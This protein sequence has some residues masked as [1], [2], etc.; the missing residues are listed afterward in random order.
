MVLPKCRHCHRL[1]LKQFGH[2]KK[3]RDF[4]G[5]RFRRVRP[6]YGV[7]LDILREFLANGTFGRVCRIGGAHYIAPMLDGV[8]AL[9]HQDDHRAFRHKSDQ[10]G[11]E[12][13]FSMDLVKSLGL[14]LGKPDHF[15]TADPESGLFDHA[16]NL[17]GVAA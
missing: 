3:E 4:Q 7:S 12:G 8:V 1:E 15:H 14:L 5:G 11:E 10:P 2:T 16:E 13:P 17:A 9:E 6:V